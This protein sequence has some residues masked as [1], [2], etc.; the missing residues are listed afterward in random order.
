MTCVITGDIIKSRATSPEQ[1][2]EVLKSALSHLQGD[3]EKWKVYR[4]D[5]FQIEL[6]DT[7]AGFISAVYIK[8][9][10]KTQTDL[11]V[12]LAIGIGDKT[13]E[14]QTVAESNGE[15]FLFS[16]ETLE[17]LKKEK[18]N[19]K[20]KTKQNDLNTTLNLLFKLA[21]IAM[22]NWTSNS[23][24]IVKLAIER[25]NDSQADIGR[26]ININQTAVS[27]RQ[28]RAYLD[29]ILELDTYYRQHIQQLN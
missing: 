9:C 4:G 11:D 5:S 19:L 8:A 20:L 29:S 2:L 15:A 13:F 27:R 25:P 10:I 26:S 7:K 22:D 17:Q 3:E 12:R 28:Q 14:G 16:G 23:A 21:L 6:S 24:E 18:T 1:W